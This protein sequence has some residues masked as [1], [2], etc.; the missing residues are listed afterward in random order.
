MKKPNLEDGRKR[1]AASQSCDRPARR[2]SPY[3]TGCQR[4]FDYWKSRS[5]GVRVRYTKQL[6]RRTDRMALIGAGNVTSIRKK[7]RA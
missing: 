5:E 7:A 3:C 4:V 2:L 1:C 6:E